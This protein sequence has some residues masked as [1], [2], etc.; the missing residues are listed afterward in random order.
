MKKNA[1]SDTL[2]MQFA[3]MHI[4]VSTLEMKSYFV[5]T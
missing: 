2:V 5:H 4:Y 3:L 1:R